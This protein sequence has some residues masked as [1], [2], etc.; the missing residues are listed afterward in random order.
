MISVEG[1]DARVDSRYA[2]SLTWTSGEG[3]WDSI[4]RMIKD[5][6]EKQNPKRSI[7]AQD[8]TDRVG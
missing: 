3:S 6:R 7:F 2:C 8:L 1:E 5:E 4:Y